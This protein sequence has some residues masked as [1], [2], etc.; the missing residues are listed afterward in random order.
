MD[1]VILSNFNMSTMITCAFGETTKENDSGLCDSTNSCIFNATTWQNPCRISGVALIG[2][3][4]ILAL[5]IILI[6]A[7]HTAS[8]WNNILMV[9]TL[10]DMTVGVGLLTA[11]GYWYQQLIAATV[12]VS[13]LIFAIISGIK[14]KGSAGKWRVLLFSFFLVL[15]TAGIVFSILSIIYMNGRKQ[16]IVFAILS[17]VCWSGAM[18]IMITLTTFYLTKHVILKDYSVV[19]MTF[20]LSVEYMIMLIISH[21]HVNYFY[22][23]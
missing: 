20:I 8:T 12:P 9:I 17:A 1:F 21:L 4:L 14:M 15:V 11:F 10:I 3:A 18:F 13:T 16:N 22:Y 23:C 2:T 19:Y 6:K 5:I 7:L